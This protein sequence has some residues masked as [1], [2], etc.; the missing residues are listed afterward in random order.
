MGFF[1]KLKEKFSKKDKTIKT[2]D[3]GLKESRKAFTNRIN[4][5][6]KKYSKIN[7]EFFEELEEILISSDCGISYSYKIIDE[8]TDKVKKEKVSNPEEITEI[9]FDTI[10]E[11]YVSTSAEEKS[12]EIK[13][14]EDRPTLIL[15]VG[16]NGVGKTTS[17]A[18]LANR[19]IKEGKKTLLIAADTFRAGAK[20]QLTYWSEKVN[21]DVVSSNKEG[22]DPSSVIYDGLEKAKKENYDLI[23][24]D[25]AGRL[26][27]KSNLMAELAKMNKVISKEGFILNETLL[28]LDATTGQNGVLQARAFKDLLPISGIILTKMDGTSKGGIILAINSE[29]KIPVK[30][31]GLGE[32]MDDLELFS[33]EKYIHGLIENE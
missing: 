27:N 10:L 14:Y 4:K 29:L 7:E 8:L 2:Y 3:S 26:Q 20:E 24:I 18:K 6:A 12:N 15:I 31:I 21:S 9:L 25:T 23:I 30:F 19:Y 33:I 5:L 17:I 22:C 13:F 32:K 11:D 28:V 16:V 1:A